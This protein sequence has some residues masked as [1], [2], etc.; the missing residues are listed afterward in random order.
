MRARHTKFAT[1]DMLPVVVCIHNRLEVLQVGVD[2]RQTVALGYEFKP[3]LLNT[4]EF[5]ALLKPMTITMAVKIIRKEPIRTRAKRPPW[6]FVCFSFTCPARNRPYD[7]LLLVRPYKVIIADLARL[8][9][10]CEHIS[11]LVIKL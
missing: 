10:C 7:L 1:R 8:W 6:R 2:R 4:R 5:S 11:V 9:A 3:T